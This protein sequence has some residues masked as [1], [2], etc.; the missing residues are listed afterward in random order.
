MLDDL[1]LWVGAYLLGSVPVLYWIGKWRG[2]DL[3][4]EYDAHLSLWRRVGPKEGLAGIV[5]DISKGAIPPMIGRLMGMDGL[6][7]GLSGLAVVAG[8]MWPVFLGFRSGEKGNTTGVGASFAMATNAM[9]MAAIPIAIGAGMRGLKG[10]LRRTRG[11]R[12]GLK[13]AGVSNSMPLG[14]LAGFASLPFWAWVWGYD[15]AIVWVCV[16]LFGL[17]VFRR[18]T[19]DLAEEMEAGLKAGLAS[20]LW[21]RFL[22]DRSYY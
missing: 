5:W 7:V 18:L 22:Y 14:M 17:I 20:V 13:F 1:L 21:N 10:M 19:A 2:V 6:A 12:E 8:Q 9:W 11:D 4:K 16:G 15:S 3:R